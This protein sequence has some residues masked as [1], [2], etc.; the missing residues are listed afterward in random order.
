VARKRDFIPGSYYGWLGSWVSGSDR[1]FAGSDCPEAVPAGIV[2]R[3]TI[4]IEFATGVDAESPARRH[5]ALT[6]RSRAAEGR[7]R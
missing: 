2:D 1:L 5:W 7:R 3:G 4:E 6:A